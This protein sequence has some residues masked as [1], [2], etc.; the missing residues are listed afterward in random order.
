MAFGFKLKTFET[1]KPYSMEE[2][3]EA[4]KDT[5]FSAGKPELAKHG[6][7]VLI[8]FPPLDR[9]NQIRIGQGSMGK[10]PCSKFQVTKGESVGMGNMAK[11]IALHGLTNGWSS[12]SGVL[13]KNAKDGE[14]L[15]VKTYEELR[16]LSL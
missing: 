14:A 12:A 10:G 9:N 6:F 15:V 11:G 1:S 2:L 4:I 5:E 13:G 8:V 7:A 16:A 3:Y